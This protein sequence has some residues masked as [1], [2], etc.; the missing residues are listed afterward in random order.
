MNSFRMFY[1]AEGDVFEVDFRLAREKPKKGD[2][3][4]DNVVIW[5]DARIS[6]VHRIL[7]ISHSRLLKRSAVTLKFLKKF[8]AS[9]REKI[10]RAIERGPVKQFLQCC[11]E[12]KCQY[13]LTEPDLKGMVKAA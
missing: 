4:S 2:E 1:D 13:I 7:F 5:T 3:L 8:S 12:D 10:Q 9:Q 11:D 6:Q